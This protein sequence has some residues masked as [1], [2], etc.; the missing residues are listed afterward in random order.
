MIRVSRPIRLYLCLLAT[1]LLAPIGALQAEPRIER[2]V[3]YGE[4]G[5]EK[6]LLDVYRPAEQAADKKYPAVMLIHGGGWR[7]GNREAPSMAALGRVL[8]D[9]GYVAFSVEY[10]LVKEGPGGDGWVNQYPVPIDDCRRAVRWVREHAAEYGVDATK[11]G[12]AGDSAGG[13]LVS[14]LGTTDGPRLVGEVAPPSSRVQAVV[15]IFGPADLTGDSSHKKI[16]QLNVQ[17]LVDS[18]VPTPK[19]KREAS[20][21]FHIDER[22]AAFLIFHGDEDPLVDVKQSRDFHAALKKAERSSEYVEFPGAGHGFAGKDW[23]T[24]V[25]KSIAFFDRELK[26]S[27]SPAP[28]PQPQVDLG[29]LF[30]MH[31]TNRVKSF[32]EQNLVFQN[33]VLVGDSI[34]EGFDVT[35]LLPGRRVLNRGIGADVIGNA[36][37]ADDKRGVLARMDESLFDCSAT[38]VFLMIGI[39]DLGSGRT[40]EV[41][42][43]GYREILKQIKEKAPGIRVHVQSLLPCRD[44]FAKHNAPVLDF[45]KRLQ[46]LAEE[47]GYAYIDL[48]ALMVDDK[49][50]LKAEF[51]GDGLHLNA[52]GY[53]PWKAEVE[54]VMGW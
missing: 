19:M 1:N 5:G 32:Q 4:E 16:G 11:L 27:S 28:A 47:F 39:N 3:V 29:A 50:E 18:F 30:R 53:E 45:N 6:L 10:R 13:H 21:L 2:G 51:T 49:G 24:L 44:R 17:D 34:T 33:V 48:H 7:G 15:D 42:E 36:L 20:P 14:M 26:G 38:D 41:M 8:A 23:D 37:P 35:R 52:A 40:P 25:T 31:F 46:K 22:S 9:A 12:A 54:R 43:E